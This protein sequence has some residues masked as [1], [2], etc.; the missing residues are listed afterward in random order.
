[1]NT[2]GKKLNDWAINKIKKEYKDDVLL[3]I[4]HDTYK[5]EKDADKASFSFF[6]PASEKAIGLAKT[7]IIDGVGYDLF[8]MSWERTERIVK[9]EED[10][11]AVIADAEILYYR[12]EEDKTRFLDVQAKLQA[13]LHD[14]TFMLN[15]AL[16]KVNIAMELYQTMMF[17]ET[18]YKVRKAAG[19]IVNFL[20]NAVAYSN[21]IY[22]KKGYQNPMAELQTMKSIPDDFIR[23]CQAIVQANS[24]NEL[25]KLCHEMIQNTRRFLSAKKWKSEKSTYNKNFKDLACWYHWCDEKDAV[26]AFLR[27]SY[28]QSELDI[29]REEFGLDELDLLGT[30]NANNLTAYRKRAE[31]LEKQI[32]S[33]IKKQG[34]DIEVYDSVEEFIQKNA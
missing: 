1:M 17:E 22:F 14:S 16:E 34:V 33:I 25:K 20:S 30:F 27:S 6:Y 15:K 18:L 23:L 31:I 9:L 32:I 26:R 2:E 28:L 29:V 10:N 11:A 7:F 21:M 12:K 24:S 5:L 19:Y 8:P 3:L 4:A 13:H